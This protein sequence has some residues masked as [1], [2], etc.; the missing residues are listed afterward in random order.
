MFEELERAKQRYETPVFYRQSWFDMVKVNQ[1]SYTKLPYEDKKW[2]RVDALIDWEQ[3]YA[4]FFIDGTF[5]GN[6]LFFSYERDT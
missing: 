6:T 2:Y 3:N 4:A 5:L 1:W